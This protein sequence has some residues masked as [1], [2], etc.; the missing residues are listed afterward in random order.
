MG[1][2]K[3]P[4]DYYLI[5]FDRH[6]ANFMR[7]E[8]IGAKFFSIITVNTLSEFPVLLNIYGLSYLNI[9]R[10]IYYLI[11]SIRNKM[12]SPMFSYNK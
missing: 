12:Y 10:I 3:E 9:L 11:T 6:F 5:Y 7:N 1:P 8:R 4:D 2:A